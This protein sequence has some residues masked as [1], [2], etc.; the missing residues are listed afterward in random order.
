M[1]VSRLE[2]MKPVEHLRSASDYTAGE[3]MATAPVL[4]V[5]GTA[6]NSVK[7]SVLIAAP[8]EQPRPIVRVEE[9]DVAA[10]LAMEHEDWSVWLYAFDLRMGSDASYEVDG[11]QY[12]VNTDFS[13]D[14]RIAFVSCNGQEHGDVERPADERNRLWRRLLAQH[15][16]RPF[17]LLLHGGD[18]VYADELLDI[19]PLF[20]Q[21][22]DG[23]TCSE[24][25]AMPEAIQI[26]RGAFLG[27]YMHNL[28]QPESAWLQSRIPSLAMWDDHD[29]CD[30]WG[31]LSEA[32]LDSPVGQALF[33]TAREFFLVF[34][35][36]VMP[37]G[38]TELSLDDTGVSLTWHL[39][40]PGLDVIAPDLRSERRPDRVMGPKG[41]DAVSRAFASVRQ[42]HVFVLSTVP[43]LGPRLS[44]LEAVV[45]LGGLLHKYE[46][47]LRDQWQSKWHREEW[48]RFMSLL[49][50]VHERTPVT[51]LSGEIHLAARGTFDLTSGP[52]HQLI[53]SGIAHPA[54]SRL[55]AALLKVVSLFPM[56]L[57]NEGTISMRP[58]PGLRARYVAQR[59]YLVLERQRGEWSAHWEFEGSGST[60]PL[61][62]SSRHLGR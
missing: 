4:Y 56:D 9:A 23:S 40:L 7:L 20:R 54:P 8:S 28:Q 61:D 50:E 55:Y 49:A 53:A 12:G 2:T 43:A 3:N 62:L 27:I 37:T 41:W 18:Q 48:G 16:E 25:D 31:S 1:Q 32:K 51:V 35:L 38:R 29:I 45:G 17:Q 42:G 22:A 44:M 59:N 36:G 39:A 60:R 15:A 46:D 34:Q 30:G 33:A 10:K 47:D 6:G 57:L 5:H 11:I 24:L 21:W 52:M 19:H 58:L 14:L 13:G 26:L